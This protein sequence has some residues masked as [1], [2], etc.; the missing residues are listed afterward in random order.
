MNVYEL[1]VPD[2][3]ACQ[4]QTFTLE[5]ML[6][7]TFGGLTKYSA[8]GMWREHTEWQEIVHENVTVYRMI[9]QH[10]TAHGKAHE[11]RAVL[12]VAE[13]VK[14]EWD[15]KSVLWTVQEID[16]SFV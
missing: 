12:H 7:V 2:N 16:A 4:T 14:R 1:Y 9:G 15:Q 11:S 8:V 3:L 10:E 6:R 5:E 13:Y